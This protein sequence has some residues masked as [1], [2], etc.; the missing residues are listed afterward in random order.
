LEFISQ[1][2]TGGSRNYGAFS[3]PDA[4]AMIDKALATLDLNARSQI[5]HDF[6]DT[7]LKKWLPAVQFYV[8][9]DARYVDPHYVL[10]NNDQL[11]GPWNP[12]GTGY[13]EQGIQYWMPA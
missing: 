13:G 8:N 6:Q 2:H 4:D 12:A 5:L 10:E 9:P 11:V 1:Y 3:D 7:Y